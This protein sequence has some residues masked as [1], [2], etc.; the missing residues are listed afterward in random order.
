MNGLDPVL[1]RLSAMPHLAESAAKSGA[2]AAA[3][4]AL[5][6]SRHLVPVQTGRLRA[7]LAAVSHPAGAALTAD[8]PY[9]ASVELGTRYSPARP[10][11][12]PALRAT[13][14]PRILSQFLREVLR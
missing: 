2:L 8:C 7:S 11:M 3:Q 6:L 9:A 10:F 5:R 1:R 4:S 14:Y 12:M 13:D